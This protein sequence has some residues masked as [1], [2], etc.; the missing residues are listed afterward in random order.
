M[1]GKPLAP[2]W[3]ETLIQQPPPARRF[4]EEMYSF[5]GAYRIIILEG[6]VIHLNRRCPFSLTGD[7]KHSAAELLARDQAFRRSVGAKQVPAGV[8]SPEKLAE[9]GVLARGAR[10]ELADTSSAAVGE[11][12]T[13]YVSDYHPSFDQMA[14]TLHDVFNR[15]RHL[16]HAQ[17]RILGADFVTD[18]IRKPF[19]HGKIGEVNW[20]PG[21]NT[22]LSAWPGPKGRCP[23][24]STEC[25]VRRRPTKCRTP[26]LDR[27]VYR[28]VYY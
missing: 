17:Q 15:A 20:C 19:W 25:L 28:V 27:K 11:G 12:T 8:A 3:R 7:G 13:R 1:S 2:V 4:L 5:S 21:W 18:D 16:R 22:V 23:T 6:R 10:V 9:L 24:P 14:R 26:C